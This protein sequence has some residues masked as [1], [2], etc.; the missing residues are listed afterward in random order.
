MLD[1]VAVNS[2]S[3]RTMLLRLHHL[4]ANADE[5]QG[6]PVTRAFEGWD[7]LVVDRLKA[8]SGKEYR[9]YN[10]LTLRKYLTGRQIELLNKQIHTET[11][12]IAKINAN[13]SFLT[14]T[15]TTTPE[16]QRLEAVLN[17]ES[18]R[19]EKLQ[20]DPKDGMYM[21]WNKGEFEAWYDPNEGR[22]LYKFLVDNDRLK[23]RQIEADTRRT[24]RQRPSNYL[25][26]QKHYEQVEDYYCYYGTQILRRYE[27]PESYEWWSF[28]GKKL[29]E[30]DVD[31]GQACFESLQ[32]KPQLLHE[33][34][35]IE[36]RRYWSYEKATKER[37]GRLDAA[38]NDRRLH[39]PDQATFWQ[40]YKD[41]YPDSFK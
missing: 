35:N 38:E 4:G 25:E 26:I 18:G 33:A 30:C 32:T 11:E 1:R 16:L 28:E 17:E 7:Y 14:S 12:N 8:D 6:H 31:H 2:E 36:D 29:R 34:H 24:L 3:L 9:L 39:L 13:K 27:T 23:Q 10:T 20:D 5:I 21:I 40:E 15:I 37:Q 22:K 41:K 19:Y